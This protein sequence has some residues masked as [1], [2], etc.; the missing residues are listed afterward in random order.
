MEDYSAGLDELVP[1]DQLTPAQLGPARRA[2][3]QKILADAAIAWALEQAL[4]DA[5]KSSGA[6]MDPSGWGDTFLP[7]FSESQRVQ[8]LQLVGL[9]FAP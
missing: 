2:A 1:E 9:Q 4:F 7:S 5:G 8:V 3:E 6:M